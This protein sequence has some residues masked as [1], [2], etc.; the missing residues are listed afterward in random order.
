M[1][2]GEN[3][4]WVA[5]YQAAL[6]EL[7]PKKLRERAD[8]TRK[9]MLARMHELEAEAEESPGER[10]AMEEALRNLRVLSPPGK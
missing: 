1:S 9:A 10:Q 3:K 5:L 6:L 2:Y 4:D 7:D 8:E